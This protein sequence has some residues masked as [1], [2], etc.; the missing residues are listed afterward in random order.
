MQII[1]N[2][3]PKININKSNYLNER[4]NNINNIN[5]IENFHCMNLSIE[6]NK[7][8][9][10]NISEG[11]IMINHPSI[12]KNN[13]DKYNNINFISENNNLN[14]NEELNDII[15]ITENTNINENKILKK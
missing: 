3:L 14:N 1:R 4:K 9:N 10:Q 11:N 12:F 5:P 13:L 7:I 2:K 8:L 6:K 15:N